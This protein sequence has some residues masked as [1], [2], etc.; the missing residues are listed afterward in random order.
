MRNP[1]TKRILVRYVAPKMVADDILPNRAV[2]HS[3]ESC[4]VCCQCQV[5]SELLWPYSHLDP[6]L[7]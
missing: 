5:V 1:E 3:P 4:Q 2:L 6:G 7:L